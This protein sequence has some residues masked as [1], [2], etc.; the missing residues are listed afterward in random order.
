LTF[1]CEQLLT[2][3]VHRPTG[4]CSVIY[5]STT[6]RSIAARQLSD[7]SAECKY[8]SKDASPEGK[9]LHVFQADFLNWRAKD[10]VVSHPAK[11]WKTVSVFALSPPKAA[12]SSC[13]AM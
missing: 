5:R 6:K 11:A 12:A 10:D 3:V 9:L 13:A 1:L 8:T 4:T 2:S 7:S